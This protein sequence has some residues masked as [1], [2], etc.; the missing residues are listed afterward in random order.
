MW[1]SST[2]IVISFLSCEKNCRGKG[3]ID[4]DTDIILFLK[5]TCFKN[6]DGVSF[7]WSVSGDVTEDDTVY[8]YSDHRL[9]ILPHVLAPDTSY[10]MTVDAISRCTRF[11][12]LLLLTIW[13]FRKENSKPIG[14]TAKWSLRTATKPNKLCTISPKVG[15][16]IKTIFKME[17][18]GPDHPRPVTYMADQSHVTTAGE[19]SGNFIILTLLTKFTLFSLNNVEIFIIHFNILR[20]FLIFSVMFILIVWHHYIIHLR[21]LFTFAKITVIGIIWTMMSTEQKHQTFPQSIELHRHNCSLNRL[22]QSILLHWWLQCTI[23]RNSIAN[24]REKREACPF[25]FCVLIMLK[26]NGW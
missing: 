21:N 20:S 23:A 24:I 11:Y 4:S 25:T 17:C 10:E 7:L 2:V 16:S 15:T 3:H 26:W 5:A 13:H 12:L 8:G 22:I 1:S 9:I 19:N 14:A 18:S 6:C